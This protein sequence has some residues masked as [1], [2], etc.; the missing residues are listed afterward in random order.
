MPETAEARDD[1]DPPYWQDNTNIGLGLFQSV[2]LS[3]L[4]SLRTGL[5][6]R[7]PSS[8]LEDGIELH[9]NE[10]WAR[11]LS[12][13]DQ[14]LLG[15]DVLRSNVG[16][17]YGVTNDLRLG[18]DF[19]SATRTTGYL[20]TFIIGF[21]RTFNISI[22]NRRQYQDHP[23]TIL[24]K[25]PNGSTVFIDQHDPQPY[26]QALIATGEYSILRGDDTVPDVQAS[27]S[28]RGAFHSGDLS[29]GS[30]IDVG[31]TLSAAKNWG[32]VNFYLGGAVS[33]Y[34]TE[35]LQGMPLKSVQWQG[36]FGLEVR[37]V[38]WFSVT[39]QWLITSGG[40]EGLSDLSRPSHEVTA[41]FKWDLGKG[42]L[43]ETAILENIVNPYNSPDFGVHFSFTVRW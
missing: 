43:L 4:P 3:P 8:L 17:M 38:T 2:S 20:E 23:Q 33:W 18:M 29:G 31:G 37:V 13:T 34:G 32:P 39:G 25:A 26:A 12:V 28:L 35:D 5:G 36:L 14:W 40:V 30:P 6:V 19:E 24:I 22:G 41:G 15:Y 21:H 11:M 27:L 9:V 7:L 16:L 10:D 1:D 42:Y